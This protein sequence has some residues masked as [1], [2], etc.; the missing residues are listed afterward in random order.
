MLTKLHNI[1]AVIEKRRAAPEIDSNSYMS[2][3]FLVLFVV[4]LFVL[5]LINGNKSFI[6]IV[7]TSVLE[8]IT[9]AMDFYSPTVI[10]HFIIKLL[11]FQLHPN[12]IFKIF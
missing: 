5:S 3:W 9:S 4:C 10:F 1:L 6:D 12:F 2:H 8:I 11:A 7:G